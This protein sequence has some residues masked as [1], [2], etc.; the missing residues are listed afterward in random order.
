MTSKIYKNSPKDQL[1]NMQTILD[2]AVRHHKAGRFKK[3]ERGYRRILALTP[4]ADVYCNLGVV[5]K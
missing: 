5:L 3:A 2:T 4:D 1:G